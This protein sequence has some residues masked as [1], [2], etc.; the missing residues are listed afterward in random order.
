M[1]KNMKIDEAFPLVGY[2]GR[3]GHTQSKSPAKRRRSVSHSPQKSPEY[4]K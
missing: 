1:P 2:G 4:K 3:A